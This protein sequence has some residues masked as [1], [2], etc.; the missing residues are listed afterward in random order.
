MELSV[1]RTYDNYIEANL[2]LNLLKDL[3]IDCYLQDEYT[4]TIDPFLSPAI[5]G[6]KLVV[7]EKDFSKAQELLDAAEETYIQT[8]P[9]KNCGQPAL[10]KV[11]R[12]E[13]PVSWWGRLKTRLF[14]GANAHFRSEYRCKNCGAVFTG[15]PPEF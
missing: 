7:Q 10:E 14:Y 8:V 11:T 4:I 13:Q 5:G 9:C 12:L 15:T 1:I 6:I 3:G 2:Q